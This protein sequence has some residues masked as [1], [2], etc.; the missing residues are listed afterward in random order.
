MKSA[1]ILLFLAVLTGLFGAGF[2]FFLKVFSPESIDFL[3]FIV[4]Y[5]L[6]S[7][8]LTGFFALLKNLFLVV[9]LRK[10]LDWPYLG[11]ALTQS[12]LLSLLVVGGLILK[13][14]GK[15]NWL[16]GALLV[17]LVIIFEAL[18]DKRIRKNASTGRISSGA[19]QN[20][21]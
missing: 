5:L 10:A 13:Q 8:L 15:L 9:V 12:F 20:F 21:S 1:V 4:F 18:Y 17:I 6:L 7:G 2:Y 16:S 14:F 19:S 3:G 11:R